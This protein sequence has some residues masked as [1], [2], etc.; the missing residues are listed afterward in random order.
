M[1]LSCI[2]HSTV[3][4]EAPDEA[5]LERYQGKRIDPITSGVFVLVILPTH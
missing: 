1:H 4:L 2:Q 3:H 5:L